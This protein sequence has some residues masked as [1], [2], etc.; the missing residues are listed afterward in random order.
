MSKKGFGIVAGLLV[1]VLVS[2]CVLA[3]IAGIALSGNRLPGRSGIAV[4]YVQGVIVSGDR[5]HGAL[6]TSGQAYSDE[7]VRFL[8]Q[9]EA[10]RDVRAIVLRVDS[11]GGGVVA[12][13]EIYQA[14]RQVDK[15]IVV[16]MGTLA[17]SGGYFISCAAREIVANP[18]TLTGS[19]GV[20][21]IMPNVQGLLDKLG[22]K[23]IVLASGPH[24]EGGT[25][26]EFTEEDR[27]IWDAL[28]QETYDNFVAVI[29]EGRNMDEARVRE[30]ADGRVY[31]GEQAQS[32]GLVDH[33]GNMDLAVERAAALAGIRGTPRLIPYRPEPTFFEALFGAAIQRS[34]AEDLAERLGLRDPFTMQYLY[35]GGR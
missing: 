27:A 13:D 12:S 17:A 4:I 20:I 32:L 25:F 16:S 34:P 21:T 11:P 2:A 33:L 19:I 14:M 18:N 7:I 15:P 28:I 3:A 24:K 5:P 6:S 9:A 31:T 29:A 22:I 30:L 26:R 10:N 1:V 8:R 23:M 35:L